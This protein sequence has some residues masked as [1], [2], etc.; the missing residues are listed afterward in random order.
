LLDVTEKTRDFQELQQSGYRVSET[1]TA[2]MDELEARL[3]Q[4]KQRVMMALDDINAAKRAGADRSTISMLYG[5]Y[6]DAR[7]RL[8]D[9]TTDAAGR[10]T[11]LADQS[12]EL[13]PTNNAE[14]DAFRRL[15]NAEAA[16][17]GP[18]ERLAYNNAIASEDIG[19]LSREKYYQR[20]LEILKNVAAAGGKTEAYNMAVGVDPSR[21]S[22]DATYVSIP[23]DKTAAMNEGEGTERAL[24]QDPDEEALF[25]MS[26]AQ[27]SKQFRNWLKF[28]YVPPGFGLGGP[29]ANVLQRQN[30]LADAKRFANCRDVVR[31]GP[32]SMPKPKPRA[33]PRR[34]QQMIDPRVSSFG[35]VHMKDAFH[36]NYMDTESRRPIMSNPNGDMTSTRMIRTQA[37]IYDPDY[38]DYKYDELAGTRYGRHSVRIGEVSKPGVYWDTDVRFYDN[39]GFD[40]EHQ[41]EL[42]LFAPEGDRTM[43]TK[44]RAGLADRGIKE[45]RRDFMHYGRTRLHGGRL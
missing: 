5:R 26:G 36:D 28:S 1:S 40:Y 35:H 29:A 2:S 41:N 45:P 9:D 7:T 27:N 13:L 11:Y 17:S 34:Y 4:D 25:M 3:Q 24:V 18:D 38:T 20:R 14:L 32:M 37:S 22:E 39:N 15:Q 16:L 30:V 21:T 12:R 8:R 19:S 44:D 42:N 43:I 33:D 31:M 6:E 23:D 10:G